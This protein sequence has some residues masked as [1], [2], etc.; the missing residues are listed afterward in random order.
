MTTIDSI[1]ASSPGPAATASSG[2]GGTLL[3]QEDFLTLLTAQL[4]N[5]DP[6]NPLDNAEFMTQMSQFSMV[7]GIDQVND[8]LLTMNGGLR[9]LGLAGAAGLVGQSALVP[10]SVTRP[11]AG[12]AIRGSV[13]LTE[14]ADNVVVTY[15]DAVTGQILHSQTLGPQ[16][17][18]DLAF[19]WTDLPP[20]TVAARD[21]VAVT[22]TATAAGATTAVDP[23][24]FA[25]VT[26]ASS[27]P[28]TGAILFEIED[29]GVA[30]ALEIETFR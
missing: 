14:P 2:T 22:V 15:S 11:D 16:P 23:R 24:V 12:G 6:L 29:L 30:S 7:G 26:A 10:G 5:Q 1:S 21:P 25:R 13:D 9:D 19:A 4:Q 8:T 27:D 17:A 3:G 20:A 18:G 28:A